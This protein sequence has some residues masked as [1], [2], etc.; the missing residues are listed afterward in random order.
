MWCVDQGGGEAVGQLGRARWL[1]LRFNSTAGRPRLAGQ[2]G[3]RSREGKKKIRGQWVG[4]GWAPEQ[5]PDEQWG[6]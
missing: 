1:R 6:F 5:M 2:G 3:R 4:R